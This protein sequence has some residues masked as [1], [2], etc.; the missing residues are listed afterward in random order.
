MDRMGMIRMDRPK[1]VHTSRN[2]DYDGVTGRSVQELLWIG[3]E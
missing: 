2:T 3:R 1:G